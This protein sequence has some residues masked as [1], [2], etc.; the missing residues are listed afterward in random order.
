MGPSL[1]GGLHES[2]HQHSCCLLVHSTTG[3]VVQTRRRRRRRSPF[4]G[5]LHRRVCSFIASFCIYSAATHRTA[6]PASKCFQCSQLLVHQLM[7]AKWPLRAIWALDFFNRFGSIFSPSM[8]ELRNAIYCEHCASFFF[9]RRCLALPCLMSQTATTGQKTSSDSHLTFK[10]THKVQYS[11][12][13]VLWWLGSGTG[14]RKEEIER[15]LKSI[16]I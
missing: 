10:A 6:P 16:F 8:W 1:L 5:S 12:R 3:V 11:T 15:R 14:W 13:H 4:S 2:W 9:T 7:K